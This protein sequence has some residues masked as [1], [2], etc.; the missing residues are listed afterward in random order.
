MKQKTLF[1]IFGALVIPL[2]ALIML[3]IS[4]S[5]TTSAIRLITTSLTSKSDDSSI[6]SPYDPLLPRR[7]DRVDKKASIPVCYDW[8]NVCDCFNKASPKLIQQPNWNLPKNIDFFW[9]GIDPYIAIDPK[10]MEV[11]IMTKKSL[12]KSSIIHNIYQGKIS[13]L[14]FEE[15][16]A[17]YETYNAKLTIRIANKEDEDEY[18]TFY[19]SEDDLSKAEFFMLNGDS[20]AKIKA[21]D[22]KVGDEVTIDH[23]FDAMKNIP[24]PTPKEGY[25][26]LTSSWG[27]N[28]V[29]LVITKVKG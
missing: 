15:K 11:L 18:T 28:T 5:S 19:L 13:I 1:M 4:I 3:Y 23:T 25:D 10:V 20:E 7:I 27:I 26:Y 22:L 8:V 24:L 14:D 21:A 29:K 2:V 16:K 6:K 12:T 17:F 9:Y